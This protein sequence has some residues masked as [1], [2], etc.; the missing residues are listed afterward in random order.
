M[1]RN[2]GRLLANLFASIIFKKTKTEKNKQVTGLGH[3]FF[4]FGSPGPQITYIYST[5]FPSSKCFLSSPSDRSF[6]LPHDSNLLHQ[7]ML[8]SKKS[9][10]IIKNDDELCY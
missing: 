4:L 6:E 2:A 7:E 1:R 3:S 10:I 8:K 5:F 9:V